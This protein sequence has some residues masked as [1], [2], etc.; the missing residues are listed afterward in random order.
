MYLK[1][2]SSGRR[3]DVARSAVVVVFVVGIVVVVVDD[4]V[5]DRAGDL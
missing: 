1:L 2:G 4:V 5:V 3:F